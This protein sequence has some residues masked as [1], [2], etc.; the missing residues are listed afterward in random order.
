MKKVLGAA[1]VVL[2][3]VVAALVIRTAMFVSRQQTGGDRVEITVDAEAA[4]ARF[5]RA[6]TFE[7]VSFQDPTQTDSSQFRALHAFFEQA[8]PLVHERLSRETVNELS[9]LYTWEGSDPDLDPILLMGHVDVVPV[10]PGTEH[11][12]THPPFAGV[13]ADGHIWGRGA[14]DD[15]SA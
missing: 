15:K 14:I 2:V 13:I 1:G 7:T 10:I 12:W 4:A 6:L 9:L 11:D 5:A 8:Y 3:L